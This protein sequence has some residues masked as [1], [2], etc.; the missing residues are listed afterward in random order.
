MTLRAVTRHAIYVSLKT[1][2]F[3]LP[4]NLVGNTKA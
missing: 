1:P 4:S 2:L 3:E